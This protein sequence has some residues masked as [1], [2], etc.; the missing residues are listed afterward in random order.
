MVDF[1]EIRL[2]DDI[3]R[4]AV[5][6]PA[7]KTSSTPLASGHAPVVRHWLQP[8]GGWDIG[9]GIQS[10]ADLELV[11]AFFYCRMGSGFGFRFKDWGDFNIPQQEI[12]VGD[13]V[14]TAFQVF[15]RY[16][17]G[18]FFFDRTIYKL[19]LGT[20]RV[21]VNSVEL[22]DP[23]GFS[24]DLN[25]GIVTLVVAAPA[26]HLVEVICEFDVPVR[27]VKDDLNENVQSFLNGSI[28]KIKIDIVR[29]A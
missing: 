13:G 14:E 23:A 7:F 20:V 25:T 24:V 26:G 9:Y 28:P 2:P 21:F 22:F 27:L 6:G 16:S 15:K 18:S 29:G 10:L 17:D 5:G 11:K 3:E 1:H 4:G 19:V 8:L 12:G